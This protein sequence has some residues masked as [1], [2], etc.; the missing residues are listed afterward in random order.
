VAG[1]IEAAKFLETA[2]S[3]CLNYVLSPV[4][5]S[6]AEDELARRQKQAREALQQAVKA[7]CYILEPAT[8]ST[9]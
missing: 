7:A 2:S 9:Q 3:G 5:R 1:S 8:V 6:M 4:F